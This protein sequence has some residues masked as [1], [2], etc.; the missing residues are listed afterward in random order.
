MTSADRAGGWNNQFRRMQ[1]WQ[2]R[3]KLA[4]AD[5]PNTQFHDALD[6][7]LA[8]FVWCHSMRDWLIKDN[9]MTRNEVDSQLSNHATWKIVRDLANRSKHLKITCNPA[10][11]EWAV[12]REYDH[13]APLD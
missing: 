5:L 4:L 11:A 1:R 10:D 7:A 2:D 8:Y 9:A 12:S 3:A 13:F 6:V